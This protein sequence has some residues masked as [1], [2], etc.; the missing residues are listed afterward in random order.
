MKG[1]KAMSTKTT[2]KATSKAKETQ[3][4]KKEFNLK[5]AL[6]LWIYKS[7]K[8]SKYLSGVTEQDDKIT[9]FFN[10]EKQNPKEPD[11]RLYTRDEEGNTSKE[12]FCSLWCNVKDGSDKKYLSGKIDDKRVVGFFNSKAEVNGIIPYI[13]IYFSEDSEQTKIEEKLPKFE[14]KEPEYEEIQE[15]DDLPF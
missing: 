5:Q 6:T 10:K 1:E 2:K 15:D 8:G 4:Q 9:G 3:T 12:V 11:I 13:N 7:K 14:K